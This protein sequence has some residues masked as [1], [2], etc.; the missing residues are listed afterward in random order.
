MQ[1]KQDDSTRDT[2]QAELLP[3]DIHYNKLLDWLLDRRHCDVKWQAAVLEIREKINSAI[4]DMPP[5]EEITQLLSGAY[6]NYFH[7]VRI[8][9]LLKV[10]ESASKNIF[11]GYSSKRMKILL[12]VCK[13]KMLAINLS[14]GQGSERHWPIV[15]DIGLKGCRDG[16]VDWQE[17]QWLYEKNNVNLAEAAHLLIRNVNYEIPSLKRQIGKCQQTQRECTRKER[18]Y[19]SNAVTF[20]EKYQSVCRQM[21]IKGENI[22]CELLSLLDELPDIYKSIAGAISDLKSATHYYETFVRFL[23]PSST[24]TPLIRHIHEHG[25]STVYQWRTGNIPLVVVKDTRPKQSR[26]DSKETF[27]QIDWGVEAVADT[28]VDIVEWGREDDVI[29]WSGNVESIDWVE[30]QTNNA[31]TAVDF[32][33]DGILA[34]QEEFQGGCGITVEQSGQ[35]LDIISGPDADLVMD[36]TWTRNL[37]IDELLELQGFLRHRLLEMKSDFDVLSADQFQSAPQLIQMQSADSIKAMETAVTDVLTTLTSM[38]MQNLFLLKTS[39]RYLDRL[40]D[41]LQQ[42]LNVSEKMVSSSKTM[43]EKRQFAAKEQM[44]L[45]PKLEVIKSKTKELQRKI[46]EEISK[47]YKNR[48]V[49]IMGEINNI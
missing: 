20:R 38:K 1:K 9:E 19:S 2:C 24:T 31:D 36:A 48:P 49:N 46:A 43:A 45:E 23:V 5:V 30:G 17:I 41:S 11:G 15:R 47:K 8:V 16:A 18:E 35:D 29:N 7:C 32:G 26:P 6:I 33:D 14:H 44:E 42:K 22:K 12:H 28:S 39:P 10:S 21:G 37:L 27:E 34:D 13:G 25:N 40:A 4:Q 3:I